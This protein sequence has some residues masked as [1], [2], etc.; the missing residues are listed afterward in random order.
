MAI[1]EDTAAL[2]AAQLTQAWAIRVGDRE[3]HGRAIDADIAEIYLRFR[4]VVAE[5]PIPTADSLKVL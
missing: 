5:V 2:V 3:I 4:K 1:S